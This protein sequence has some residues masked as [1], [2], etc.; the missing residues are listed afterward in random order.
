[1]FLQ[2]IQLVAESLITQ[3]SLDVHIFG[4]SLQEGVV[5]EVLQ[6]FKESF[7]VFAQQRLTDREVHLIQRL[8][9]SLELFRGGCLRGVVPVDLEKRFDLRANAHLHDFSDFVQELH[10]VDDEV[11]FHVPDFLL[12]EHG[13]FEDQRED[14]EVDGRLREDFRVD[15]AY[16]LEAHGL[17]LKQQILGVFEVDLQQA[18]NL[19]VEVFL[20][21]SQNQ[22]ELVQF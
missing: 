21:I 18:L 20:N 16:L 13:F 12:G 1:M 10:L 9:D 15:F 14:V 6:L 4:H 19:L 17:S 11:F 8:D 5:E 7:R 2:V 22:G 3:L